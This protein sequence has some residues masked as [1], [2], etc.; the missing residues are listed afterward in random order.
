MIC[1]GM[2]EAVVAMLNNAGMQTVDDVLQGILDLYELDFAKYAEPREI[3]VFVP[4]GTPCLHSWVK[5]TVS[6]YSRLSRRGLAP[7]I[8]RIRCYG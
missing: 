1:G 2:P 4:S 3:N 7:K 5:R 8:M 6:S